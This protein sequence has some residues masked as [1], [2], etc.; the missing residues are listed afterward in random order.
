MHNSLKQFAA[1]IDEAIVNDSF[2]DNLTPAC[3]RDAVTDYPRRGGKR[4]RPALLIWCCGLLDGDLQHA[5][6][7]AAAVEIYHNWTLV[8][9]DIIDNDDI[10]RGAPTAHRKLANFAEK[11]YAL[12]TAHATKFGTDFA[13]LAGDIQQA[14]AA[15]ILLRLPEH[16]VSYKLANALSRRLHQVVN[17]ELISGEALDIEF[18]YRDKVEL[19]EIEAMIKLKT[20][21][22]L[23]FC[24]EA[25]AAIALDCDDFSNPQ[26]NDLGKFAIN[27]GYA[28]QLRDDWLGIFG[29]PDEFGKPLCSDLAERKPTIL[30]TTALKML[31]ATERKQLENC[32]G[33]PEYTTA[34]IKLVRRLI[35]QSGAETAVCQQCTTLAT[36]ACNM[37]LKFP[38]NKYRTLLLELTEY[39]TSRPV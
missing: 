8:H 4:L 5:L 19:T 35:K 9:D 7:A 32:L 39:L 24:A 20:G 29:Q 28:F 25:G 36:A 34:T 6:P 18:S 27:A 23:Q 22:L 21:V 17:C 2:P 12:T 13:I 16:G 30:L 38:D 14:W 26:I 1:M 11:H 37:L 3:L 15:D 31:P 10:R 33:L